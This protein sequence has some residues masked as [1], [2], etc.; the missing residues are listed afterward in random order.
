MEFLI[1]GLFGAFGGVIFLVTSNLLLQW[2]KQTYNVDLLD[3]MFVKHNRKSTGK[4]EWY[5]SQGALVIFVVIS[6]LGPVGAIAAIIMTV[7]ICLLVMI[8][9]I[10]NK[11]KKN[12]QICY[13]L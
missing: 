4:D 8:T 3:D 13:N 2:I 1:Y 5:I 11:T 12:G 10:L 7:V 6:I 9:N